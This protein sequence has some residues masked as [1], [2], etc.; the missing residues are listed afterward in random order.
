V[1]FRQRILLDRLLA[2]PL[3][4]AFDLAA[5]LLGK[6]LNRNHSVSVAETHELVVCKL[7]GM[8]SIIQATP[9]MRGLKE[10]FPKARLTFVTLQANRE[11]VQ[12]LEGVDEVLCLDDGS[13]FSM[14]RT[15]PFVLGRLMRQRV[16]HY[17]DLEVYSGFTSLLSLFSLARNRLGFYRHSGQF[18]RGLFTHLVYFNTR[19]AVRRLYLQLGCVAGV[20]MNASDRLGRI[21]I[22]PEERAAMREKLIRLGLASDTPFILLNPNASDL[23]IERRWPEKHV[24]AAI[25]LL[26]ELGKN[27][28][29]LGAPSEAAYVK[30]IYDKVPTK[31]RSHV[32]NLAGQLS[33]A[34]AFA[35]IEAAACVVTNDTG[36]MHMSFA[37]ERPTV[38]LFGPVD[39]A[40]YGVARPDIVTLYA[41][42]PCS[43]C[44]HEIDE[45]PC[46][47]NNIC[48]Q[49]L[50]P[51]LV[52]EN[53]LALLERGGG[54][55]AVAHLPLVWQTDAGQPLGIV[56]RPQ[57]K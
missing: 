21:R 28:V 16:D 29:L 23:L 40:H 5:R 22:D 52:V 24:V 17:F 51:S 12:R 30:Q 45:P 34:E 44:V 37:L 32:F 36:P 7:V 50:L 55:P 14:L 25:T 43:P 42:V 11:L 4:F 35:L 2:V 47:G 27:I 20:T 48:M 57:R 10:T 41:P 39:P 6:I 33:L 56:L 19:M 8:G 9:L 38:C 15:L 53:V 46:H 49:R 13:V 31:S 3:C 26:A 1:T 18:K 54:L